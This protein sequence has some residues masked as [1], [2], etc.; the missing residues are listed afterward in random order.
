MR[1][2]DLRIAA[3]LALVL[4][5]GACQQQW[6]YE[7][8]RN[9]RALASGQY[10]EVQYNVPPKVVYRI[11]EHRFVTLENYNGCLG[12][13]WYNDT[14]TGV[15][16]KIGLLWPTGYRGRLII[17]DPTGMNVAIPRVS[18][19]VCGDRG[20][21]DYVAYSTDGGRSFNWVRYDIHDISFDPVVDS[22]KYLFTVTR[23]SM[24]LTFFREKTHGANDVKG[25][26]NSTIYDPQ[27]DLSTTDRFPLA[28]EYVYGVNG[29]LPEGVGIEFNATLPSGLRTPSGADR[30]TCDATVQ[31]GK[32]SD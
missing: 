24:Y 30:F 25:F 29:K 32:A 13:G 20:C 7:A 28:P 5:L 19:N 17:D 4:S 31:E 1:V 21:I 3:G 22:A 26:K 11:D 2:T 16:T 23:D 8:E 10:E 9:Q 12:D 14:R 15:R 6:V 27:S 18:R